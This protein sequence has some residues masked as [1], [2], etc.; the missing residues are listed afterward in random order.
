MKVSEFLGG[1]IIER[2]GEFSSAMFDYGV[3]EKTGCIFLLQLTLI[4]R[5]R[6]WEDFGKLCELYQH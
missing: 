3:R 2:N 4:L 6:G 1:K 5:N